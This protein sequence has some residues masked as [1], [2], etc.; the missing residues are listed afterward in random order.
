MKRIVCGPRAVAEALR[1]S[2]Q[3]VNVIFKDRSR[4]EERDIERRARN[5]EVQTVP[6][7]RKQLDSLA[8]GL[9]HQGYLAVTG[10]YPYKNFEEMVDAADESERPLLMLAL[11]QVQDVGNLGSLVRSC[12]A[13]DVHGLVLCRHHSAAVSP[14]VVRVSTGATEHSS[15]ARV[16]NL[17]RALDSLRERETSIVGLDAE[18]ST[19]LEEVDLSGPTVL[20]LG[21]EGR[22]IRRLVRGR[23]DVLA[24]IPIPG[25]IGSLNVATAGAVA[26]YETIRQRGKRT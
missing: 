22:G 19:Q 17:V 26:L 14:A 16:T 10:Y 9:R 8:G 3:Q 12:V 15:I 5:V 20:V 7:A 23:C 1:A 4:R 13:F 25:P 24:S 2:P 21:S 18:G 6:C 11:D